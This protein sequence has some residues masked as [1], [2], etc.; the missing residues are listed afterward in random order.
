MSTL[1]P[2]NL[3]NILKAI[4]TERRL[5]I[6]HTLIQSDGSIPTSM[7]S[8]LV[9]LTE[10]Q[11]SFNLRKMRELGIVLRDRSGTWSF[12]SINRPLF[13]EISNF[14]DERKDE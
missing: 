3:A 9:D 1:N 14:F 7:I 8:A 11:T 13:A 10:A 2:T 6:L 5:R 4:S 12:Y